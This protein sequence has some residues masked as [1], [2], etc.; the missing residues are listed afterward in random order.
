MRKSVLLAVPLALA[1]LSGSALAGPA[2]DMAQAHFAAI[3][4]G[5]IAAVTAMTAPNATLHW[6]GGPL[7][8]TYA[9]ANAQKPVWTK[10]ATAQGEQ[11]TTVS[12]LNE[13]ANPKGATVTANVVFAG[14]N[15]VKVRYVLLYTDG[16]L[17]DEVWQVDGRASSTRHA[18]PTRDAPFVGD[19]VLPEARRHVSLFGHN[20]Q[21][22]HG[23][24]G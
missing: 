17:V 24:R 21:I 4:K 5:D 9:G 13:A 1:A 12:D 22:R 16:K 7:D 20:G 11:K 2:I 10:F 15:G 6:V 23:T 14:K 18:E 8:G 19:P 3:A